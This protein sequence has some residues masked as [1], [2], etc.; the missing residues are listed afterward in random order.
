[1]HSI[2]LYGGTATQAELWTHLRCP[3]RQLSGACVRCIYMLSLLRPC[4]CRASSGPRFLLCFWIWFTYPHR[5]ATHAEI[6]GMKLDC[7]LQPSNG[8]HDSFPGL[9]LGT[10]CW[11]LFYSGVLGCCGS[12]CDLHP[13][14]VSSR[15]LS[16]TPRPPTPHTPRPVPPAFSLR[17]VIC[18]WPATMASRNVSALA[19]P[20]L[21][22]PPLRPSEIRAGQELPWLRTAQYCLPF[23][24][25]PANAPRFLP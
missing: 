23:Q 3:A 20:S 24:T 6:P 8:R 4:F 11:Y 7:R 22:S 9:L 21:P 2:C 17:T 16:S 12:S 1:M 18:G 19:L 10:V 25:G 13:A 5:T 15:Y 14:S